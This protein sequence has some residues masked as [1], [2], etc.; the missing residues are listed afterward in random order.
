MTLPTFQMRP[1]ETST[2]RRGPRFLLRW[3]PLLPVL[4][5]LGFYYG[6]A[7]APGLSS[8]EMGGWTDAAA[9][10][11]VGSYWGVAHSPGYPLY[12]IVSN[13]F[14]RFVGLIGP[15][16]EPAWRVS[17]FSVTCAL[18]ALSLLHSLLLRLRVHPVLGAGVAVLLGSGLSFWLNAITAEVYMLNLMLIIAGLR[19]GFVWL[20]AERERPVLIGLGLVA[21]SI[22][23]HHRTGLLLYPPLL[24]W[25][26]LSKRD[27]WH[28][29]LR[30]L[31]WM[32]AG[33][34]PVLL[35]Y[36]YLPLAASVS[37]NWTRIYADASE[38]AVFWFMV[39]SREWWGLVELPT[40]LQAAWGRLAWVVGQQ[41]AELG[42]TV[43]FWLG[44]LGLLGRKRDNLLWAGLGVVFVVFGAVYRVGDLSSML[45]PLT[46]V[47]CIGLAL[48]VHQLAV[49]IQQRLPDRWWAIHLVPTTV[50]VLLFV[51]GWAN[52]ATRAPLVDQSKDTLGL[53]LVETLR[54][55][56]EDGIPTGVIAEGNTPLAAVQYT[57]ARYRLENLEP[58]SATRFRSWYVSGEGTVEPNPE[59]DAR[60]RGELQGRWDEG[61]NL[62]YTS[63]VEQLALVPE[64]SEGLATGRYLS[65]ATTFRDLKLLLPAA[66][67]PPL[68]R[69]PQAVINLPLADGLSLVGHDQRWIV[70]RTGGHLRVALYLLPDSQL[71][72]NLVLSL[73]PTGALADVLSSA[74]Y[75]GFFSGS[76]APSKL[77]PG[78]VLRD[79]YELRL[80]DLPPSSLPSELEVVIWTPDG[81]GGS[82]GMATIP[83]VTPPEEW[84]H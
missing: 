32:S 68:T 8:L 34:A 30:R 72:D 57:R 38:P 56:S 71:T 52:A 31:A 18:A 66:R 64:I 12:T 42:G 75:Q 6:Q 67:F 5:L 81:A 20:D 10:Q 73:H 83:I 3:L 7:M 36:L 77:N 60:V 49:W 13:L 70:K 14:S 48:L 21:G 22:T 25:M 76:L 84:L 47:L 40:G 65:A 58:I 37:A 44:A 11:V 39:L 51:F 28:A 50:G 17:L 55:L 82:G 46:A 80:N 9:M 29:W 74:E 1:S 4:V 2:A 79:V 61:T 26:V 35:S 62:Y 43:L 19:L 69:A 27:G 23:V 78:Q 54:F 63:E 59:A 41:A 16:T 15:T 24:T 33:G 53:D 45:I